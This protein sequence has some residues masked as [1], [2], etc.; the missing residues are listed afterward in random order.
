MQG[1]FKV[2]SGNSN[3]ML[4]RK[5]CSLIGVSLGQVLV[6]C[7]SDGEIRVEINENVRGRD[8]YVLQSTCRPVN[9]HLMELL[10]MMDALKRASVHRIN[11]VIP[12]YGYGR[13]D[14]KEKPRVAITAKMVADLLRTA[15]ADQVISVDL[16]ATQIEGFFNIPVY[17]LVS[18]KVLLEDAEKRLKGDEVVVAPDAGGVERARALA[19]GLNIDLAMMDHRGVDYEPSIVGKVTDR[20]VII[21]DDMVD[22]GRTL[23]RAAKSAEKTGASCID[24]YCIHP[25]LSGNAVEKIESS[26]IR[27]LTVTDTI[28]LSQEAMNSEKIRIL[29]IANMLAEAIKRIHSEKPLSSL[30]L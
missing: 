20:P 2:F 25:V 17:N 8:V 26:P 7:F 30:F 14:Q 15:G 11:A 3:P 12:Y 21:L 16:H 5:V 10:L 9:Q 4:A 29:S 24:A 28:P 27:S 22:T 1:H 23:I 6:S 19:E 18:N 13:Q